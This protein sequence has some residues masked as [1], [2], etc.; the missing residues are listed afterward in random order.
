M[1]TS[2]RPSCEPAHKGVRAS[3]EGRRLSAAGYFF[4]GSFGGGSG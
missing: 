4:G 1:K 2:R 3:E